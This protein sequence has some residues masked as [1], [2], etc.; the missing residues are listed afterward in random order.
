MRKPQESAADRV[1]KE[2]LQLRTSPQESIVVLLLIAGLLAGAL[3]G[4]T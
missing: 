4:A 2:K 1:W 3:I